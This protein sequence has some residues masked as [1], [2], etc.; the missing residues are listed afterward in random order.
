MIIVPSVVKTGTGQPKVTLTGTR[1]EIPDELAIYR[2]G[3]LIARRS[4]LGYFTG[5]N[6]SWTDW[7]CPPDGQ[8]HT[9]RVAPI[10]NGRTAKGGP[11]VNVVLS[12]PDVWLIDAEDDNTQEPARALICSTDSDLTQSD[13]EISVTHEPITGAH[14]HFIRRKLVR[15]PSSGS[16]TGTLDPRQGLE[17]VSGFEALATLRAFAENDAGHKYRLVQRGENRQVTIGDLSFDSKVHFN[18]WGTST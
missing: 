13:T 15:L 14:P 4:G 9:Y 16:V 6:F 17:P 3:A 18:W 12:V 5:T 7:T 11:V 8:I 10:V 2:D 1:T